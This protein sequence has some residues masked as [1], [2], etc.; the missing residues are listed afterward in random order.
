MGTPPRF[1]RSAWKPKQ[2]VTEARMKILAALC[3]VRSGIHPRAENLIFTASGTEANNL[4]LIGAAVAKQRK[5]GENRYRRRKR[6]S[7]H[8]GIRK[9][10]GVTWLS[11]HPNSPRRA[12]HGIWKPT[13]THW[14][15]TAF[16][17]SA[18]LVNNETGAVN[19]IAEIASMA[20]EANP[21]VLVPL[22][23]GPGLS[24]SRYMPALY[25]DMVTLS[26]HKIAARKA[27]ARFI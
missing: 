13:A 8:S 7:V 18:M 1:I 17:S 14:E 21:E 20:R 25:A 10:A 19:D 27:S 9:K 23:C 24:Q 22:R 26:A 4:A 6:A 5:P 3:P 12:V 15:K 2:A 16:S 11:G